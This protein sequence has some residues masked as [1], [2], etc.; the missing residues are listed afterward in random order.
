MSN[1]MQEWQ[2]VVDFFEKRFG[3]GL[4]IDAII[5]LIGIQELG[6]GHRKLSKDEKVDVMHISVCTLLEPY[7][8]YEFIGR[9]EDGWPHFERK[10]KLPHLKAGEQNKLMREAIVNYIRKEQLTDD[11]FRWR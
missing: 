2:G 7:G 6:M 9:D 11:S 4:D 3:G 10:K 1:L 5:F 8:Y